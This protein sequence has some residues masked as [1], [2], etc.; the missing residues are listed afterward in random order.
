MRDR[1]P[2]GQHP[3]DD[4]LAPA[5]S[6]APGRA[7]QGQ[8]HPGLERRPARGSCRSR[9][10]GEG[11]RSTGSRERAALVFG[12][13]LIGAGPGRG[14]ALPR[15]LAERRP[16]RPGGAGPPDGPAD[17]AARR[18]AAGLPRRADPPRRPGGTGAG[19]ARGGRRSS[20]A[21][22]HPIVLRDMSRLGPLI[23]RDDLERRRL[24]VVLRLMLAI[25]LT[26]WLGLWSILALLARVRQL[27]RDAR[28][29]P[30]AGRRCIAFWPHTSNSRRTTYAYVQPGGRAPTRPS[31]GATAIPSTCWIA[32]PERQ[33]RLG[34]RAAAAA[35][36]PGARDRRLLA[37]QH[38]DQRSD[39]GTARSSFATAFAGRPG[40]APVAILGW[41][42]ILARGRMP[43][44]L[45]DA[46]AYGHRP[47]APSCGPTCCC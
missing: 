12:D 43:R 47:T 5:R 45:R 46:A 7:L 13:R 37:G 4:P 27:A 35:G 3:D 25:P 29:R 15:E 36:A 30:L 10:G 9:C 39:D 31:T 32:P 2:P 18:A 42:A 23:V 24:T 21:G 8:Q 34:R 44:G 33:R 19:P 1:G 22:G 14:Q 11:R 38:R 40:W 20:E 26:I 28:P 16:G 41:F 17:R 6:R